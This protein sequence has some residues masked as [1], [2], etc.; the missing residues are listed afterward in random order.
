MEDIQ[1][2]YRNFNRLVQEVEPPCTENPWS[3]FP[4]DYQS[5]NPERYRIDNDTYRV[6]VKVAKK[7]CAQCPIRQECLEYAVEAK[8][9]WGIWGGLTARER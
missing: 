6:A 8:E 7:L 4:E 2:L 3:F 9:E 5:E 1:K